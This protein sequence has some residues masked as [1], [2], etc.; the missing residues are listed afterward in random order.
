MMPIIN[1]RN[2]KAANGPHN[3][4]VIHHHDQL[5]TI[6]IPQVFNTN[7]TR[8]KSPNTPVLILTLHPDFFSLSMIHCFNAKIQNNNK[9]NKPKLSLGLLIRTF[10]P[11]PPLPC[12]AARPPCRNDA[13]S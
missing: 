4:A 1:A 12:R 3:G 6:P 2:K 9:K 8:N 5:A 13:W 7:I 10:P 11:C